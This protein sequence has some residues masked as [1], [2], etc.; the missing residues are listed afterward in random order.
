MIY[1][2]R[3]IYL[4][5]GRP[6]VLDCHFRANPSLTNLYWE[7]DGFLYDPY[8]VPG[9]FFKGNGSLYFNKVLFYNNIWVIY[10]DMITDFEKVNTNFRLMRVMPVC[11]R[12]HRITL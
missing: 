6:S 9:V 3:E 11:I 10:D 12:V 8:N 5:Y 2:P 7:K 4:P 1:T